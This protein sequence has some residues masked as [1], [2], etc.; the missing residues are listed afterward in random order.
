MIWHQL[1]VSPICKANDNQFTFTDVKKPRNTR[2]RRTTV[3][4]KFTVYLQIYVWWN[5]IKPLSRKVSIVINIR[6]PLAKL[7]VYRIK[8]STLAEREKAM[9]RIC[10]INKRDLNI[11]KANAMHLTLYLMTCHYPKRTLPL[12]VLTMRMTQWCRINIF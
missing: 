3:C 9:A 6:Y 10:T 2:Q 1:G 12:L 5:N 7:H 4:Y 11:R 8:Y